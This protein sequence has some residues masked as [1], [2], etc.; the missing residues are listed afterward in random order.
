MLQTLQ[1]SLNCPEQPSKCA[2]IPRPVDGRMQVLNR[3]ALPHVID[4]R[5]GCTTSSSRW[6]VASIRTRWR[7]RRS[8]STLTVEYPVLPPVLVSRY[9]DLLVKK[10]DKVSDYCRAV[11][12]TKCHISIP[13]RGLQWRHLVLVLMVRVTSPSSIPGVRHR[14]PGHGHSSAVQLQRSSTGS[15]AVLGVLSHGSNFKLL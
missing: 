9:R 11:D 4:C 14:R 7:E 13:P 1:K 2:T 5:E 8:V 6:T 10:Q 12:I 15:S 3:K